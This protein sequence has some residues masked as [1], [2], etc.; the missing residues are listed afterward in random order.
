MPNFGCPLDT[1][2]KRELY[3][4]NF[5]LHI[6]QCACLWVSF[7][8]VHW[9]RYV[10]TTVGGTNHRQVGLGYLRKVAYHE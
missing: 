1:P 9:N 5:L 7:L 3:L 6:I 10:Y 4:M 8:T 2:R